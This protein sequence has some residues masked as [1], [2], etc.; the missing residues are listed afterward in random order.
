MVGKWT[1][2]GQKDSKGTRKGAK[3]GPKKGSKMDQNGGIFLP[4]P[5]NRK[6]NRVEKKF[7]GGQLLGAGWGAWGGLGWP[8]VGLGRL[9]TAWGGPGGAKWPSQ[10]IEKKSRPWVAWGGLGGLG[11]PEVVWGGLGWPGVVWGGL[12]AAWG[13][14]GWPGRGKIAEPKKRKKKRVEIFFLKCGR[15]TPPPFLS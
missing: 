12:G 5:E 14:L 11:W 3:N 1:K 10:K 4:H 15:R 8:G 9:G 2:I 6:K 7:W 13:G